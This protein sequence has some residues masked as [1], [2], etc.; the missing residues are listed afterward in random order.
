MLLWNSWASVL[1]GWRSIIWV[2]V[3]E[4]WVRTV[5]S[6]LRNSQI[7]F[8]SGC[9]FHIPTSTPFL[10]I[11]TS[12]CYHVFF[13]FVILM[14]I[15][16]NLRVILISMSL[17]TKTEYFFKCFLSILDSSVENSDFVNLGY[18]LCALWL[19]QLK[20]CWFSQRTSSLFCWFF[21]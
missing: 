12:I 11:L 4:S 18:C 6:F 19:V 13:I 7:D 2:Y 20:T 5:L 1:V 16:W 14:S 3:Q 9:T 15:R 8:Q 21:V 17:M 10:H